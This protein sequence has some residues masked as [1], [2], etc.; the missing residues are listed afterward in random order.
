VPAVIP[1]QT[2]ITIGEVPIQDQVPIV[3]IHNPIV[4]P[5]T[6]IMD[7]EIIEEPT[8]DRM[9]VSQQ[10]AT[11]LHTITRVHR[12][13]AEVQEAVAAAVAEVV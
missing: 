1:I 10:G 2:T 8:Q 12:E 11:L 3:L 4:L 7:R 6:L 5:P 13:A 9:A